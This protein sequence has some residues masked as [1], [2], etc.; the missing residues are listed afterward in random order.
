MSEAK[1][2]Q[3]EQIRES[4]L[5]WT[6]FIGSVVMGLCCV[7]P[8][9]VVPLGLLGLSAWTGY[10]DDVLLSALAVFIGITV[11]GLYRECRVRPWSCCD[12][13]QTRDVSDGG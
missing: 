8:M 7:T 5:V 6:G 13:Q 3:T 1:E 10:L 11:Y 2:E 4:R 12:K 9:L